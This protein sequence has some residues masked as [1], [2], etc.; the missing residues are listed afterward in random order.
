M[1]SKQ[2]TFMLLKAGTYNRTS[3]DLYSEIVMYC[4]IIDKPFLKEKNDS[5]NGIFL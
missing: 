5:I 1:T 3:D 4:Q 2:N